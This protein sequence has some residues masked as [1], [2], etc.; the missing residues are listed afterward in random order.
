N[1]SLLRWVTPKEGSFDLH[2]PAGTRE[3]YL[4][5]IEPIPPAMRVWWRY[6]KVG[7]GETLTALARTYHVATT[8]IAQENGLQADSD[9]QLDSK[10]VIPIP[11]GKRA[12]GEDGATYARRAVR[13]K[14]HRGDTVQSVADNFSVPPA[15]VRR[16]NH[17]RG[18][19][20]RGRRILYVHL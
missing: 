6:H 12:A 4:T 11:A 14:I 2:L 7:E 16:W 8:S 20:L 19:G 1:P 9:L 13:Y 17:L 5:A 18:D 15:M 10:L 3:R